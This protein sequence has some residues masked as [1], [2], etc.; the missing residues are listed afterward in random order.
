[1][2]TRAKTVQQANQPSKK[3]VL[4]VGSSHDCQIV[5]RDASI[6]PHHLTITRINKEQYQIEDIGSKDGTYVKG[7]KITSQ[8]VN[9]QDIIQIGSR[10]VEIRWLVS[11]FGSEVPEQLA[12][13]AGTSLLVG[14]SPDVDIVLPYPDISPVHAEL[15][16]EQSGNVLIADKGSARGTFLNG[17]QVHSRMQ[18]TV[19]DNLYLGSFR[20]QKH[21]LEDWLE[22]LVQLG[23]L[24]DDSDPTETDLVMETTQ[25]LDSAAASAMQSGSDHM[26][27]I[28]IPEQGTLII[29]RDPN[30]DVFINHD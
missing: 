29:G 21:M 10:P 15:M 27:K 3:Q 13:F 14:S 28:R 12:A 9:R 7:Q 23:E 1:M 30:A 20:V 11:H 6:S 22:K 24:Y 16:V 4:L 2:D 18:L 25:T 19:S 5:I 26:A 8:V 17:I